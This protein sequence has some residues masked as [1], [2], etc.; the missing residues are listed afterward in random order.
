MRQYTSRE[1]IRIVEFNGFYYNRCKGGHAIYMND[2]GRHISIPKNLEC[3]I[4]RRLIKENN[5]VIDIK[6]KKN[7]PKLLV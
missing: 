6:R 3:V 5:L 7:D 2:K 1:F 4:A